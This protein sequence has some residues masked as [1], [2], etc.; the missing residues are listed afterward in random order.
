MG[1]RMIFA[2]K[3]RGSFKMTTMN[4]SSFR[5][6]AAQP[7]INSAFGISAFAGMTANRFYFNLQKTH[8]KFLFPECGH[9]LIC[10]LHVAVERANRQ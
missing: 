7:G 10:D 9:D 8:V 1:D 2:K 3:K 6:S 4:V 5:A